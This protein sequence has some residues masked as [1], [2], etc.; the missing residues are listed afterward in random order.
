[1]TYKDL[2]IRTININNV[3][4]FIKK[5]IKASYIMCGEVKKGFNEPYCFIQE[6]KCQGHICRLIAPKEEDTEGLEVSDDDTVWSVDF[7]N[8]KEIYKLEI[9]K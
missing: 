7:N 3:P 8:F 5:H 4:N 6:K 1:M 9:I 2:P